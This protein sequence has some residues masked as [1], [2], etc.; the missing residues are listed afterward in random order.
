MEE[1]EAENIYQ[2]IATAIWPLRIAPEYAFK[3]G[4][5]KCGKMR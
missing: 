2:F 4:T 1:S 3:P 5:P